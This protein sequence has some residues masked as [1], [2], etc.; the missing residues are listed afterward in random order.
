MILAKNGKLLNV[1]SAILYIAIFDYIWKYW[2]N[3][4]YLNLGCSYYPSTFLESLPSYIFCLLPIWFFRGITKI[5]TIASVILYIFAY[6]PIILNLH[7]SRL[8]F[9][10]FPVLTCQIIL[11]IFMS[12]FFL[13]DIFKVPILTK[14]TFSNYKISFQ[15]LIIITFLST[16]YLAI[17][18][19]GHMKLA[20]FQDIYALR[21]DNKS[22]TE[23]GLNGYLLLWTTNVFYPLIF[24]YGFFSRRPKYIIAICAGYL[25]TFMM[26]GQKTNFFMPIILLAFYY[27]L[28]IQTKFGIKFF[29][30]IVLSLV[31]LS[32]VLLNTSDD[33]P[34]FI[35]KMILFYRT[36]GVCGSI[37]GSYVAFFENNPYTYYSHI[38]I[39][40][41]IT[42]SYPY[43]TTDLGYVITDGDSNANACFFTTDGIAAYGLIGLIII[44][45]IFFVYLVVLNKIIDSTQNKNLIFLA[46]VPTLVG[47]LNVSFFTYLLS[48]G[49]FLLIILSLFLRFPKIVNK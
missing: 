38:G 20:N 49:V 24:L 33:S 48:K 19:G 39:V 6:I 30:L 32:F 25:L 10:E 15:S 43:G 21:E 46:F 31:F 47:L 16:L 36:M 23:S 41:K 34:I 44:C 18:Y 5:S 42:H 13:A 45:L 27:L 22:I 8:N 11:L 28:K 40:N 14:S 35:F 26:T 2:L 4:Y 3:K 9:P 37:F 7:Y 1:F 12:L 29:P 17:A